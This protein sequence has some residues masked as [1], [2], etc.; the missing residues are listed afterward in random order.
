MVS[1]RFKKDFADKKK[2]DLM[3]ASTFLASYL[4]QSGIVERSKETPTD[5]EIAEKRKIKL[6]QIEKE[7]E[8]HELL[9]E[10]ENEDKKAKKKK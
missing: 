3:I 5:A 8:E 6:A 4:L 1:V 10:L 9:I 7:K 2:G